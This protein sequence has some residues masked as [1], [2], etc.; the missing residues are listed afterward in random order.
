MLT[1]HPRKWLRVG[2]TF[3]AVAIVVGL[4]TNGIADE[5]AH[6]SSCHAVDFERHIAP[7]FGRLGCNSAAC[8]GA[9]GGGKGGLQL[10][11]FGH[12]AK[13]DYRGVN[14]RIDPSDPESS[15]LL[16]KPAGREEHEG[17]VRFEPD[18]DSYRNI[19]Q[20]IED[21]AQWNEGS[22]CVKA[23]TVDPSQVVFTEDTKTQSLTVTAKFADGA[24]EEVTHLCQFTSR[25]EGIAVVEPAVR[26]PARATAIRQSLSRTE[27]RSLL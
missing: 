13:M 17:G 3:A 23:L 2:W 25:D 18:S 9:F 27:T 15:L 21:G 6:T 1:I 26:F 14:D 24:S 4:A 10:S 5:R 8:H 22:G 20:W 7:L 12:S 19:K 11:L 16:L